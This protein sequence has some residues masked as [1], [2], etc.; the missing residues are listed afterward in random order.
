VVQVG[1]SHC[2]SGCGR[3]QAAGGVSW[4][5]PVAPVEPG[6]IRHRNLVVVG[7][8]VVVVVSHMVVVAG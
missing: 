4:N 7:A 8:Q 3:R 6:G 2:G 5:R 1:M